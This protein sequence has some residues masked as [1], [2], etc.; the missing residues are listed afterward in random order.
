MPA[1]TN[2][3]VE[4]VSL[5]DRAAVRD[6]ANKTEAQRF[7]VWK[8]ATNRDDPEGGSMT[9]E[10]MVAAVKKAEDERDELRKQLADQTDLKANL[11]KAE[12]DLAAAKADLEKATKPEDKPDP[13]KIDKSQLTPEVRAIVEKAEA[14]AQLEKA[15]R[16]KLTKRVEDA[17]K[18]AKAEQDERLTRD[19]IA[20]AET[21]KALPVTPGDFGIVLKSIHGGVDE[22]VFE[23][24]ETVLKA[25]DEQIQKG[26]LFKEQGR[27]GDPQPSTVEAEVT[28]KAEEIRK[29][30]SKLSKAE[31]F[32][33]ALS[34]DRD[35]QARYLAEIR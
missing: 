32:D 31:A 5:V 19:F 22:K 10:E 27:A 11:K 8:S 23:Q 26:D 6:P 2:L 28:R 33:R 29:S 14:D 20:K 35:L 13:A 21:F 16:E 1:L 24:L 3:D 18:L 4:Y 30:D 7:L 17:E 15:E 9:N 12:D 34:E 25:A